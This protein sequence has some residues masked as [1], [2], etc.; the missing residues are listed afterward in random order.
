[1]RD[2]LEDTG[3]PVVEVH[4]SDPK[5]REVFRHP[6]V[7]ASAAARVI[8]GKGLEGYLEALELV[9]ELAGRGTAQ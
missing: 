5:R 1:L 4:I 2:A 3:L 9:R 8:C 6:M 7:T